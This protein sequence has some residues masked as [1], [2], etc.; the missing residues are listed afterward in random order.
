MSRVVTRS[1][2][3]ASLQ[4]VLL[5]GLPYSLTPNTTLNEK[6]NIQ[7]GVLPQNGAIP[8][9]RYFAIGEGGHRTLAGADGV[10]YTAPVPHNGYDAALFK[11]VPFALRKLDDDLTAVERQRY[12]LRKI[13][14]IN[15]VE[16][17]AYYLR[18]IDTDGVAPLME[19]TT[20]NNGDKTTSPFTPTSANLNPTPLDVPAG[21]AIVTSGDYLS[22]SAFLDM[23]LTAQDIEEITNAALIKYENDLRAVISEIA[24][25][26]AVDQIVT[27]LGA[28][29]A[30]I[31]YTEALAATVVTFVAAYHV[32]PYTQD[33]LDLSVNL[34]D[35]EPLLT[36]SSS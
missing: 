9:V 8:R 35:T 15:G 20:V 28:N 10:P 1:I 3:G 30:S 21:G 6:F 16:Y 32:L 17:A 34:G 36:V 23:A 25:V 11:H 18:R 7:A 27:G 33:G 29:G 19:F 24:I 12:G 2:Y 22:A 4:T 13:E 14:Q 31:T 26:A 5:C